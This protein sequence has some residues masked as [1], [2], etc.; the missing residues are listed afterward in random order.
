MAKPLTVKSGSQSIDIDEYNMMA[1]RP[2]EG[3]AEF[4]RNFNPTDRGLQELL[5]GSKKIMI[6]MYGDQDRNNPVMS[7]Y[8]TFKY[9]ITQNHDLSSIVERLSVTGEIIL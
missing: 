1:F 2:L 6:V 3:M 9:F 8:G 4:E 7:A 5:S